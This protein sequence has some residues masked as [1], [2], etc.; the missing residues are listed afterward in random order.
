M[1]SLKRVTGRPRE[2]VGLL[3]DLLQADP[4][5]F[6]ALIALG[7]TLL[8]MGRT[9]DARTAFTRVRRFDPTHAGAIFYEGVLAAGE[10]R[11][12]DAVA[13]WQRVI[14]LEPAGEFAKRARREMRTA[15]DLLLVFG[16]RAEGGS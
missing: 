12:R 3:V 14:D 4:Y 13:S 15:Q 1:A 10:K 2:A 8:T 16:R 7:E 6:E 9:D 11:Y 5:N